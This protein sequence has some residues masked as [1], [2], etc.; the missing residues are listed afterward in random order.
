MNEGC[1]RVLTGIVISVWKPPTPVTHIISER[2]SIPEGTCR[3]LLT[4]G[5]IY[6]GDQ[7]AVSTKKK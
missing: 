5:S 6:Q 1:K 3:A 4:S 2:L 7:R